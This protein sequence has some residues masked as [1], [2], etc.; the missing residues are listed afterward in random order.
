MAN[1]TIIKG[2]T[3]TIKYNFHTVKPEDI[4][5]AYL[6]VK[7]GDLTVIEKDLVSANTGADYLA[8]TLSQEETLRLSRGAVQVMCN[9]RKQD[10][11]RGASNEMRV[12]VSENHKDEVI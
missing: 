6:T 7:Q 8:W 12:N 3:P 1:N 9:W 2:T 10:G 5:V 11:T 4:A